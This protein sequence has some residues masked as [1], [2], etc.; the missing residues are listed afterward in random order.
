MM[1]CPVPLTSSFS[2]F[3]LSTFMTT[4][5]FSGSAW[6]QPKIEDYDKFEGVWIAEDKTKAVLGEMSKEVFDSLPPETQKQVTMFRLDSE[7]SCFIEAVKFERSEG[8]LKMYIRNF[9][10]P[11]GQMRLAAE[12][13]SV[14]HVIAIASEEHGMT[15]VTSLVQG[16]VVKTISMAWPSIGAQSSYTDV[17]EL[18][19]TDKLVFM[20]K[21]I[22]FKS[23]AAD[24]QDNLVAPIQA[25][26]GKVGFYPFETLCHF[27][28][29]KK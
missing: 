21:G 2:N 18:R 22:N 12:V 29:K 27:K 5:L 3:L 20:R 23:P 24:P 10:D 28:K 19:S 4:L 11:D 16:R 17:Y 6:S 25:S 7:I 26:Y 13:N 9:G 8:G 1:K 14:D 15:S